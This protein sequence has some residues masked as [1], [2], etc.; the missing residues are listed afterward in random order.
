MSK[1]VQWTLWTH[2]EF[3]VH[4]RIHS[5][6]AFLWK[7]LTSGKYLGNPRKMKSIGKHQKRKNSNLWRKNENSRK[8]NIPKKIENFEKIRKLKQMENCENIGKIAAEFRKKSRQLKKK[9]S[10]MTERNKRKYDVIGVNRPYV[11]ILYDSLLSV[12]CNRWVE[13]ASY[14][15]RFLFSIRPCSL[16]ME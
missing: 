2:N 3:G 8:M 16:C 7:K 4:H 6:F 5:P 1:T 15:Q 9:S 12:E 10:R 13:L 14:M 11:C